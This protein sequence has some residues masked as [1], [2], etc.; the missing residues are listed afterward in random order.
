MWQN[1]GIGIHK[2]PATLFNLDCCQLV[3]IVNFV[4]SEIIQVFDKVGHV[5]ICLLEGRPT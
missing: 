5:P 3:V 1:C 4:F 2:Y